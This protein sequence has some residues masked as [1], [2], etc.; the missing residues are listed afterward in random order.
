MQGMTK[1]RNVKN[2]ESAGA[3]TVV[4]HSHRDLEKVRQ[5]C[6][7]F[8]RRRHN[9]LVFLVKC[10]EDDDARLPELAHEELIG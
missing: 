8:E 7:E 2:P 5:I 6:N 1:M 3:W 4:S 9:P 10:L